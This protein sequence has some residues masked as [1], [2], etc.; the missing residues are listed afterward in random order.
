MYK[1]DNELEEINWYAAPTR[2]VFAHEKRENHGMN[3]KSYKKEK[4]RSASIRNDFCHFNSVKDNFFSNRVI[5]HWNNL[6]N[7]VVNAQNLNSF[8]AHLD[9][10]MVKR[11]L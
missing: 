6:P 11:P 9:S 3:G 10:F 5:R 2:I 1:V 4:L 8:K 7:N